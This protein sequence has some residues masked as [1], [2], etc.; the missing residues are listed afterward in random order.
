MD[1]QY[2]LNC[3]EEIDVL[4]DKCPYCGFDYIEFMG[5]DFNKK[6]NL[7]KL[8]QKE[9]Y[10]KEKKSMFSNAEALCMGIYP[11]DEAYKMSIMAQMYDE[12]E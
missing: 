12:E 7:K 8:K 4:V 2:C 9:K 10:V 5:I 1:K 6:I 11:K 3:G